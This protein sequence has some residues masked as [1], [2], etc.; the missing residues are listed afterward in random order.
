MLQDSSASACQKSRYAYQPKPPTETCKI[1][2]MRHATQGRQQK[3]AQVQTCLKQSLLC[4]ATIYQST[5]DGQKAEKMSRRDHLDRD[6]DM[7]QTMRS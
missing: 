3:K 5:M 6:R 4:T 7:V 2:D 1:S